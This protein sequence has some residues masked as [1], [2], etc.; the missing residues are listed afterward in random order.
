MDELEPVERPMPVVSRPLPARRAEAVDPEAVVAPPSRKRHLY[1]Q[2][3]KERQR[4]EEERYAG[5]EDDGVAYADAGSTEAVI[6]EEGEG[7]DVGEDAHA[8]DSELFEESEVEAMQPEG[9]EQL[10]DGASHQAHDSSEL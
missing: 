8:H 6:T 5:M 2:Q 1:E 4:E 9:E 10:E 3:L 7:R